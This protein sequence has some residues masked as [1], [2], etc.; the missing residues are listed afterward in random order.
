MRVAVVGFGA[1]GLY[2]SSLL[3]ES[4][5]EFTVFEKKERLGGNI[6][7]TKIGKDYID[8]GFQ[9][10]NPKFYPLV[11]G[12]LKKLG[13]EFEQTDMSFGIETFVAKEKFNWGSSWE[14][15]VKSLLVNR[16]LTRSLLFFIKLV[17]NLTRWQK[18]SNHTP[19]N[20]V[21]NLF[22]KPLAYTLWSVD[23]N[24]SCP[25]YEYVLSFLRNHEMLNLLKRTK[26]HTIK[27]ST[28]A[29]LE[30]VVNLIDPKN[31][32][33]G[34][35]VHSITKSNGK[36]RISTSRGP[37]VFDCLFFAIEQDFLY[38]LLIGSDLTI[39]S[40]LR[41]IEKPLSSESSIYVHKNFSSLPEISG[42]WNFV[43]KDSQTFSIV[44]DL[45]ILQKKN[46]LVSLNDGTVSSECLYQ[47]VLRHP[48]VG[49]R[50]QTFV[51]ALK[52]FQGVENVYFCGSFFGYG[53]HEDAFKSAQEAFDLFKC[54]IRRKF[55]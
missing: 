8:L 6:Y 33:D 52:K 23:K 12:F 31:I 18:G 53:F 55:I 35:E 13:L 21:E 54:S 46:Y 11:T 42:A 41:E 5:I 47:T 1:S 45:R 40:K 30:A 34:T 25:D 15:I 27:G 7:P 9:V 39:A 10:F 16:P 44:Y 49:K 26:W 17:A 32:R 51:E 29:Y 3:K 43:Q 2:L 4:G 36:L 14:S 48:I 28:K 38:D 22:I 20:L 50:N 24:L 19:C 37:E